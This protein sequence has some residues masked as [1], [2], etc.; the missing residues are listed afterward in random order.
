MKNRHIILILSV[1]LLGLS[2][3]FI[4]IT[5][6]AR[7]DPLSNTIS[8]QRGFTEVSQVSNSPDELPLRFPSGNW[9]WYAQGEISLD[10]VLPMLGTP[11][12]I[13]AGVV[14]DDLNQPHIALLQFGVAP[15]G[16]GVPYTPI[17]KVVFL[18]P[19]GGYAQGCVV[20][21]VHDLGPWGIEV[22]L[23][24]D[25]SQ[26]P[27]RSQRNIDRWEPLIPGETHDLVFHQKKM[28]DTTDRFVVLSRNERHL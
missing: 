10:P 18:V 21:V 4:F 27:L 17:G 11:V 25:G 28:L 20:R 9:P 23:F 26:E 7:A 12:K 16:I 1:I 8:E 3:S 2:A 19:P 24:Q 14:N 15:L 6:L 13:C 5:A 22:L